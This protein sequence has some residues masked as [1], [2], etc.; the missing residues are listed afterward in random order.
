MKSSQSSQNRDS[1][2]E[3]AE[4]AERNEERLFEIWWIYL[5]VENV[6]VRV[7]LNTVHGTVL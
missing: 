6:K 1:D 2:S 3:R 7:L 5:E 4:E